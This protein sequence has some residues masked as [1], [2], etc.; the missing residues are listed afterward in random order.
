[1]STLPTPLLSLLRKFFLEISTWRPDGAQTRSRFTGILTSLLRAAAI[2]SFGYLF[3]W[4]ARF[5]ADS[6]ALKV[7]NE[8]PEYEPS[9]SEKD[10]EVTER[11]GTTNA[12]SQAS[13]S[14]RK[15]ETDEEKG[16]DVRY[17]PN[18][19]I[20]RLMNNPALFEPTRIPRYPIA[21]A[22]G[23]YGYDVRGIPVWPK[24]Q[25]HYWN[26]LLQIL[27]QKIGAKVIVT[28]APSTGSIQER[29]ETIHDLL[30]QTAKGQNLNFIAHSMGGLDCRYLI[31]NL[32]PTEYTPRTLTTICTPHRGSPFMDWL[33][34]HIGLGSIKDLIPGI[35]PVSPTI[36]LIA[37]VVSFL[38]SPAY[39]NLTSKYLEA[40]FNP[41][42]PD[43]PDV[44]YWSVAA[45]TSEMSF[46]H[47]LWIPKL[48]I[49]GSEQK[50][51]KE[52]NQ[53]LSGRDVGNDGIVPVE[54]AKWGEFLGV[55]ENCDHWDTRGGSGIPTG[56]VFGE[57]SKWNW[58]DW[59]RFLGT[60]NQGKDREKMKLK[61]PDS[62]KDDV[63]LSQLGTPFRESATKQQ[64]LEGKGTVGASSESSSFDSV[65]DWVVDNVPGVNAAKTPLK[66]V[67]VLGGENGMVNEKG[68]ALEKEKVP[69]FD[70]ERFYAALCRKLYDE[71]Y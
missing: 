52:E 60:W 71:G 29:A 48:I 7:S 47:P 17:D 5:R 6:V 25:V 46:F 2:P 13:K 9:D 11:K 54:S 66:M 50:S 38:D 30:K 18:A 21:L 15:N 65:L 42:T 45:R 34:E 56:E 22:H 32:K 33:M 51:M 3:D 12:D 69:K 63:D 55:L 67:G 59:Q 28:R 8:N 10:D 35:S 1:M 64:I 37:P 27:R 53:S 31:S 23:L 16:K 62:R 44:R 70:L 57:E 68:R 24:V 61:V 41:S 49:D 43:S 36:P 4:K 40:H 19:P 58:S 39:S 20:Y 26:E 14:P